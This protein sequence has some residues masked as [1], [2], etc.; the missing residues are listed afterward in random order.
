MIMI[1]KCNIINQTSNQIK[2]ITILNHH[3]NNKKKE[4]IHLLI[5]LFIIIMPVMINQLDQLFAVIYMANQYWVIGI[6]TVKIAVIKT[7]KLI[8][9][10]T[11]KVTRH[12]ILIHSSKVY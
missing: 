10:V 8:I 11:D 12:L 4:V 1:L 7:F 9:Q 6:Q 3:M 2:M 5:H